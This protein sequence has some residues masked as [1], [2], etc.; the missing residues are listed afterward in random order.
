VRD[1]VEFQLEPA[2]RLISNGVLLKL[3]DDFADA[4]NYGSFPFFVAD[5]A[6]KEATATAIRWYAPLM[7]PGLVQTADYA[8]AILASTF[9]ITP[10]EVERQVAERLQRQEILARDKPPELRVI[11]DASVLDRLIGGRH[12]MAEQLR[13]LIE[14]AEQPSTTILVIPAGSGAHEGLSGE[15]QVLDSD[16]Q[17]DFAFL[18]TAIGGQPIPEADGVAMLNRRW[19]TLSGEATSWRASKALLEE[20]YKRWTRPT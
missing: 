10:D 11:L 4:M 14:A 3:W 8:R 20:S 19:V 7:M 18:E 17:P 5:L 6:D 15:F 12:V 16:G 2:P 1:T 9:G 13:R